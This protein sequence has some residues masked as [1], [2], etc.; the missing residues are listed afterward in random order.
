[1][2]AHLI[3]RLLP[4]GHGLFLSNS[5]PV[6]DVDAYAYLPDAHGG[7]G[8]RLSL[9]AI[10]RG[11]SGIDGILSSAMGYAVGLQ[12]PVT[13]LIGDMA[14][15]HDLN[16]LHALAGS[17][18]P[19]TIVMVNNGGG[20]IFSFLPIARHADIFTPF[21][22]APHDMHFGPVAS[23][24]ALP[25][26]S[27]RT[28]L[29]LVSALRSAGPGAGPRI[30]EVETD[31]AQNVRV[32]RRLSSELQASLHSAV[33][34]LLRL[35]WVRVG[36]RDKPT[37]LLLHGFLGCKED[38]AP[39]LWGAGA[40][41][42]AAS[43]PVSVVVAPP[44]TT[45]ASRGLAQDWDC[46]AVDLPG[47]GGTAVEAAGAKSHVCYSMP[48]VALALMQ[49]LDRLGVGRCAVVGYSMG[50]RMAAYLAK[51]FPQRVSALVTV[52]SHPV[53]H[54]LFTVLGFCPCSSPLT[55]DGMRCGL[56]CRCATPAMLC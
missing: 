20:G 32:H 50:G 38:W 43:S 9:V 45:P 1:M 41:A 24:F 4:A 11:A 46:V 14:F 31:R 7:E 13:L 15:L 3:S 22:D 21:F 48:V 30:I 33:L 29:E 36:P 55:L 17:G 12:R 52:S 35:D 49:L 25:H 42:S 53:S 18:L 23:A 8:G 39:L 2:V 54:H 16:A 37:L 28:P 19:L 47:H 40:A 44:T 27:C 34:E 6:R 10:N 5:M 26:T 56:G 51:E